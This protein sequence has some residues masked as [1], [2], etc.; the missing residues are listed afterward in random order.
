MTD[1]LLDALLAEHRAGRPRLQRLWDYYR[2]P[3]DPARRGLDRGRGT[4]AQAAGLPERLR[5]APPEAAERELVIENDIAWRI[6]TLVEFAFGS[7]PT[8]QSLAD[9]PAQRDAI[10]IWSR[11]EAAD[12]MLPTI[13]ATPDE[14]EDLAEIMSE[15]ETYREEMFVRFITGQEPL[16]NFDEFQA[17]LEQMGI[18][19][20]VEI[21][22]D[23][24]L[25]GSIY[26]RVETLLTYDR[27]TRRLRLEPVEAPRLTP[28]LRPDDYRRLDAVILNHEQATH[29]IQ[30][31]SLLGRVRDRLRGH[32]AS[33]AKHR[34]RVR[35]IDV[36]TASRCDR[37]L[38][39]P[40]ALGG[41]TRRLVASFP[42][43]LG[44]IP[45]VHIQN[46]PQPYRFDGLSDV[47]PLIPLQD[48]LNTRLSD[49]ANRI[50]F[51]SFKMFLGVGIEG[52]HERPI[53]PGQMWASDNPDARIETF[54]GD[55][56]NPSE[57]A[58]IAQVR[59]A[60]DKASS[61]TPVAAGL[62]GGKV[63]NL[64]SENAL[65]IVLMGLLARTRRKRTSYGRGI[66]QLCELILHAADVHGLLRTR[67]EDRR[68]RLD[69]PDPL[70]DADSRRLH[71]ALLK[72]Q[73]GVPQRHLLAELG[74]ADCQ[75]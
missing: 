70:P 45:V 18:E 6:D 43:P 66:E 17:R 38:E 58:H 12:H 50:T 62:L 42:N 22:H 61:V 27:A 5:D 44:R 47:E 54:G 28:L 64:T 67:P 34:Q 26:G 68:V 51:Q 69:W 59:E 3:A 10:Q 55:A 52:F 40:R 36:W 74:Y 53:G 14:A 73:L 49:R 4:L 9:D 65:R 21:Y 1:D 46:A 13:T 39:T 41:S 31:C 24:A 2:N 25:L 71:D 56:H 35:R 23:L 11:T 20:A 57:E 63:G 32:D 48:E 72:Q 29:R 19:R 8:I 37:Y 15:V 7:A 16:S 75:T 60:L 30:P 33:E